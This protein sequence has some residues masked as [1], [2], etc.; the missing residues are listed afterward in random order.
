MSKLK[1]IK[2]KYLV[3]LY[4]A[5]KNWNSFT[6]LTDAQLFQTVLLAMC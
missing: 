4:N 2:Q 5:I 1:I 6:L 3:I